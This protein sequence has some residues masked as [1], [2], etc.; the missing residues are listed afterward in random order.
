MND[1][2]AQSKGMTAEKVERWKKFIFLVAGIMF[3]FGCH[4]YMQEL[5]MTLPGFKVCVT[6]HHSP[7]LDVF[8]KGRSDAGLFRSIRNCYMLFL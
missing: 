7:S 3:F 1:L 4:N 5:I 6:V 8:E 2:E